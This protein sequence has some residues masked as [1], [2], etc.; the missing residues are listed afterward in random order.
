MYPKA[1]Q[2]FYDSTDLIFSLVR[3]LLNTRFTKTR[4]FNRI[5]DK[6][7]VL[8]NGPSLHSS[9]QKIPDE[10]SNYDLVAV[11]FMGISE[12]YRKYKP[13]VYI[14]CDPGFWS[15]SGPES[16]RQRVRNLY[17]TMVEVTEWDLQLYFPWQA[18]KNTEIRN[19]SK[20][21]RFLSVHFYNKTKFEGYTFLKH[22]IYNRQWGMPRAQNVVTAALM[23]SIYSK[24]KNIYLAGAD[25]DWIKNL[26]VDPQNRL[27]MAD[28]HF[29]TESKPQEDIVVPI[30][31]HEQFAALYYTFKA[32]VDINKYAKTKGVEIINLN[33]FSFIDAFKKFEA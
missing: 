12:E 25:N 22:S 23:L 9:M 3:M 32:Y 1:L 11:N 16:L 31:I 33:E 8:A 27:R 24:Y 20:R 15:E 14:F 28:P 29:Y 13:S 18:K 4:R 7:L 6:C 26:W 17:S 19:L 10:L 5:S 21:N 2:F 30:R